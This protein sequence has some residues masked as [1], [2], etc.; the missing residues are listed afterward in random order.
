MSTLENVLGLAF[1]ALAFPIVTLALSLNIRALP[2]LLEWTFFILNS[3][4]WAGVILGIAMLVKKQRWNHGKTESL[5][6][7]EL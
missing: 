1:Q 2:G 6:K 5:E 3:L 4:L 7:E